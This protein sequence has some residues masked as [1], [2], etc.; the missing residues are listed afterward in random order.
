VVVLTGRADR[1]VE[2][3][4]MKAGA[5]DYL[6]K[7]ELNSR[8]LERCIRYARER[9]RARDLAR[10]ANTALKV[11]LKQREDDRAE[12]EQSL[13]ENVRRLVAPYLEKLKKSLLA[14]DQIVCLEM[15]EGCLKEITS[16][17]ARGL[18]SPILGLTPTEIRVSDL[19]RQG[20]RSKEIAEILNSTERAVLFHRQNIRQKLGLKQKK[21]NL[22]AYLASLA[23]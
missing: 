6:P 18:S 1:D 16:P 22:Q 9:A 8:L 10:E 7:G 12:L 4:V 5:D 17:F 2:P 13:L 20:K 3:E 21:L 14:E 19:V 23:F 11:L 15:I